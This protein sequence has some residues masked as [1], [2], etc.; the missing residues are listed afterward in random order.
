MELF[1]HLRTA[2]RVT[3]IERFGGKMMRLDIPG[4]DGEI[5]ATQLIGHASLYR[6]T[7]TT[8]E[9]ARRVAKIGRPEPVKQWELPAPSSDT[10]RARASVNYDDTDD[11]GE[12]F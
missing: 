11:N 8:E 4:D 7:I 2:G 12:P 9:V 5:A 3:E 6:V 10:M 1:G